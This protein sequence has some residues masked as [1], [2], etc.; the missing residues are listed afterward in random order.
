MPSTSS[1]LNARKILRRTDRRAGRE[2]A[3]FRNAS[4][5]HSLSKLNDEL[6]VTC[7]RRG[8]FKQLAERAAANLTGSNA[9]AD[10]PASGIQ[11]VR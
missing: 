5:G 6:E 10:D 1:A 2:A 11:R 7:E 4:Y 9:G 3:H 8:N